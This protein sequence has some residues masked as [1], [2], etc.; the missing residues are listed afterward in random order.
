LCCG[1]EVMRSIGLKEKK[2]K[3]DREEGKG[4]IEGHQA[5]RH[6]HADVV[7][8][9]LIPPLIHQANGRDHRTR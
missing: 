1:E 6:Y 3:E 9:L 5:G 7:L 4:V 2:R 8:S